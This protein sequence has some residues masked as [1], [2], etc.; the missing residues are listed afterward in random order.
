MPSSFL[1]HLMY[2]NLRNWNRRKSSSARQLLHNFF[3]NF[4][5]QVK[6]IIKIYPL[7]NTSQF[8]KQKLKITTFIQ[9]LH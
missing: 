3:L 9:I 5:E 1:Q 6:K 2:Q 4:K 8:F 7:R